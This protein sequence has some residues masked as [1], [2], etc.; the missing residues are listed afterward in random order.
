ML[1]QEVE[2]GT[3]WDE[4]ILNLG[5]IWSSYVLLLPTPQPWPVGYFTSVLHSS[6]DMNL[7]RVM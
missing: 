7:Y 1:I 4:I 5:E 2:G 6:M 3:D